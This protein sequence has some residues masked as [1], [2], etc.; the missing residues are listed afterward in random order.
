[1]SQA[2]RDAVSGTFT[3]ADQTSG[4]F[5]TRGGFNISLSGFGTATV[6]LQR[7]FDKGSTYVDVEAFT[8]SAER[9]VDDPESGV[10]YRFY[11][12]AHS[13]GTIAYRL[14]GG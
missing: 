4:D 1:M 13:S 3:A 5:V 8:G 2:R 11:C 14:S 12:T 7:S 6:T 10:W 9:R